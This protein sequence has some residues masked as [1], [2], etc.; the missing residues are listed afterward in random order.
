M[1][2]FMHKTHFSLF[3]PQNNENKKLKTFQF[4]FRQHHPIVLA[5]N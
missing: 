2:I 1:F 4:E 3:K 5:N